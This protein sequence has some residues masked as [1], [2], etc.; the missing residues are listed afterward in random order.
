MV[1]VEDLEVAPDCFEGPSM[2]RLADLPG[3]PNGGGYAGGV[4][5]AMGVQVAFPLGKHT[6]R[7]R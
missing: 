4:S 5:L 1:S 2:S 6:N 7:G 3:Y